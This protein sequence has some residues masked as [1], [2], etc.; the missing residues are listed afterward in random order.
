MDE[1]TLLE[2]LLEQLLHNNQPERWDGWGC[3]SDAGAPARWLLST[4]W[5]DVA[6]W[7]PSSVYTRVGL[8]TDHPPQEES[9]NKFIM[10]TG[11]RQPLS[12]DRS[13]SRNKPLLPDTN[14]S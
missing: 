8:K 10:V 7:S 13:N 11:Q 9:R 5:P 2:S 3:V 1:A 4:V 6:S 14:L 12:S